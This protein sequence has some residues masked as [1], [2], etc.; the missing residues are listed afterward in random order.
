MN[1]NLSTRPMH[2]GISFLNPVDVDG[3][4]YMHVTDYAIKY[5]YDELELIGPTHH[6]VKGN[7]DGMIFNKK[8]AQFVRDNLILISFSR[9]KS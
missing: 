8:Y 5:G 6:G 2:K 7:A 4:Y 3:D 1:K 9:R